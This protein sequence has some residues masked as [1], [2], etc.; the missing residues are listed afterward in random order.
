M[1]LATSPDPGL[2]GLDPGRRMTWEETRQ[3]QKERGVRDLAHAIAASIVARDGGR[4]RWSHRNKSGDLGPTLDALLTRWAALPA[5]L[6]EPLVDTARRILI[7]EPGRH[8]LAVAELEGLRF[9]AEA[10][11]KRREA[12]L[13]HALIAQLTPSERAAA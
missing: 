11:G 12:D 9:D 5:G 8:R 6:R 4:W 2:P 1:A 7:D 10:D 3:R 13:A